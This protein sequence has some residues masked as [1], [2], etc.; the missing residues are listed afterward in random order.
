ML[1]FNL[2]ICSTLHLNLWFLFPSKDPPSHLFG[3]NSKCVLGTLINCN[4]RW[5][6]ALAGGEWIK[7]FNSAANLSMDSRRGKKGSLFFLSLS[8][9]LCFRVF[10]YWGLCLSKIFE[11]QIWLWTTPKVPVMHTSSGPINSLWFCSMSLTILFNIVAPER[12]LI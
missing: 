11:A 3:W 8:L 1:V 2:F 6:V 4:F 9:S 10:Y 7:H 5:K 12:F